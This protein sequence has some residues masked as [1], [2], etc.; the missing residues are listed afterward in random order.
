M[1]TLFT[2][3]GLDISNILHSF[4]SGYVLTD[5]Y[6]NALTNIFTPYLQAQ[7]TTEYFK[8]GKFMTYNYYQFNDTN[9]FNN[10]SPI[11]TKYDTTGAHTH[12][13]KSITKHYSVFLVAGGGG[14]I[15]G[16]Q[17]NNGGGG[18]GGGVGLPDNGYLRIAL[19]PYQIEY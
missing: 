19:T 3:N 11:I 18:A 9:I 10:F 16:T 2:I 1:T 12:T 15:G 6:T 5:K 4:N 7:G 8:A 17:R 13:L 14:G